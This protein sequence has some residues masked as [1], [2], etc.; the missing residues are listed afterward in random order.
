MKS[1]D[2]VLNDIRGIECPVDNMKARIAD[3][4]EGY[5][6]FGEA[7]IVVDRDRNLD[8]EDLK[9]YNIYASNGNAPRITAYV[10]EGADRYV[11]TIVDAYFS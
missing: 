6:N 2:D 7:D 3:A 10:R 4:Y 9:G 1:I 11:A 5:Q 8:K